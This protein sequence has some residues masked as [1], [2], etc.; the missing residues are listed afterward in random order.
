MFLIPIKVECHS[1]YKA[2][3]FPICFYWENIKFEIN[4]I[5]DRWYHSDP[6]PE[7]P[8]ADYFKVC[9]LGNSKYIIKH[10]M[11]GDQWFIVS[12]EK[13]VIPYSSN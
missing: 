7:G 6:T 13:A 4:E 5:S 11:G 8:V 9:T 12:H 2:D 3:E 1:G 10:E